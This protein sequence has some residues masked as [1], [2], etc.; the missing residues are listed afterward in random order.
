MEGHAVIAKTA[1]FILPW[2]VWL[3]GGLG[4]PPLVSVLFDFILQQLSSLCIH[5]SVRLSVH[6][7]ICLSMYNNFWSL[8]FIR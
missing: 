3:K 1:L 8:G 5:P 6:R 2:G 4:N 7:S